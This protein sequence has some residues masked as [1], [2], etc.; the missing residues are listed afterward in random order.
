MN[1]K[2]S[3]PKGGLAR[4]WYRMSQKA[5]AFVDADEAVQKARWDWIKSKE[6]Y[7]VDP[8]WTGWCRAELDMA[9]ADAIKRF[10]EQQQ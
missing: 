9:K 4:S 2:A 10:K 5:R 3:E 7:D 6:T 1:N 8:G